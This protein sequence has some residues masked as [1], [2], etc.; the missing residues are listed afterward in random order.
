MAQRERR[1]LEINVK[2]EPQNPNHRAAYEN[3]EFRKK[4]TTTARS[5]SS[6]SS[7]A[8]TSTDEKK[9]GFYIQK[10]LFKFPLFDNH[11]IFFCVIA[12]VVVVVGVGW[13]KSL[14]WRVLICDRI[15]A[16]WQSE[17][18]AGEWW[19]GLAVGAVCGLMHSQ[20]ICNSYLVFGRNKFIAF[21]RAPF[22][23]LIHQSDSY[24]FSPPNP[25]KNWKTESPINL[26]GNFCSSN[27]K[28]I[29]IS[30]NAQRRK[31]MI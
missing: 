28:L 23:R 8:T 24:L 11:V 21:V 15:I 31:K 27:Y 13:T 3:L 10:H 7:T 4:S 20:F 2:W 30:I 25:C 26:C 17:W 14:I 16:V 1:C 29:I 6:S 12:D 22:F 19:S 18:C 9:N 5:F